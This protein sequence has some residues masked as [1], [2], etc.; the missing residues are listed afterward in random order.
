MRSVRIFL[1]EI[2][3]L[4]GGTGGELLRER[5]RQK[6]DHPSFIG[7]S[8]FTPAE[9]ERRLAVSYT[10]PPYGLLQAATTLRLP[11]TVALQ[12]TVSLA[13]TVPKM[14][15]STDSSAF[16]LCDHRLRACIGA[17]THFT[18]GAGTR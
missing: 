16:T 10:G 13:S 15:V 2:D 18:R 17:S 11:K 6:E 3:E 14:R 1:P 9:S 12:A 4:L 5:K 7:C 8:V